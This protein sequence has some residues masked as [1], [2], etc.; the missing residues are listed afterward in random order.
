MNNKLHIAFLACGLALAAGCE[1]NSAVV[2][3]PRSNTALQVE[4]ITREAMAGDTL[5]FVARSADTYG[6][7][8]K[9]RW[10]STAGG[11]DT[12]EGG[13]IARI[14][15]KEPGTYSVTATLEV[16]GRPVHTDIVEVRV[17]PVR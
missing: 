15:F 12:E 10:A 16:D 11:V 17:R 13:R 7:D 14:Q 9:I 1:N 8:A 3:E 2:D 5:T 4:A 6:R